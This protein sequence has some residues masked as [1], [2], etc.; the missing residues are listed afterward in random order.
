[1]DLSEDGAPTVTVVWDS[2]NTEE[3]KKARR[4]FEEYMKKGRIAFAVTPENRKIQ[5]YNFDPKL[6]KIIMVTLVEGG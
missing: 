6:E 2:R 1:M 4:K 3:V 5:I